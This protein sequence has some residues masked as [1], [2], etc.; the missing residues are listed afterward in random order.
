MSGGD[1]HGSGEPGGGRVVELDRIRAE[2]EARQRE[3]AEQLPADPK[4]PGGR[5]DQGGPEDPRFVLDCLANN[6]RGDGILFAALHR[7]R[8]LCNKSKK[9]K[10]WLKWG[11]HHWQYDHLDEAVWAVEEVA[12]TYLQQSARFGAEVAELKA[13]V[14]AAEHKADNRR[15]A[16]DDAGAALADAEAG[17]LS[18][19]IERINK[20]RAALNRRVDRLR[21]VRGA[22]NCL[23][24]AHCIDDPLAIV[25]DELDLQPWL[26]PCQNGVVDLRT[27]ELL[28]GDP[29]DLLLRAVP[30]PFPEGDDVAHYLAT[31]EGFRGVHW[32][33]FIREIHQNDPDIIACLHRVLGYTITGLRTEHFVATFI[34]EG[35]NGKGTLFETLHDVLGELAWSI[36]PEMILQQRNAKNSAGPS[37]DIMSLQGRRLVVAS[38]TEENRRISAA[39]VKRLTGGDTLTGRAP[40]DKYEINFKPTHKLV[41]YTNHPPKGLASDFAMFR[42]LLYFQYPLRYVDDP[43]HH[44]RNDPQNAH[45]YRQKDPDLPDKLKAEAPWI[46]AWLVRGCLLWQEAGGINPPAKLRAAAEALRLEEDLLGRFLED[47]VEAV[48]AAERV[49]FKAFYE[50]FGEWYAENVDDSDRYRP[51]KKAITDQLRRKG[52]RVPSARETGGQV[53]VYGVALPEFGP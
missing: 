30:F 5:D 4:Q 24:W 13:Q 2:V 46:L 51:K 17:R 14:A 21:S 23:T 33:R 15:V 49:S 25:G 9:D 10:A 11:G 44:R 22:A 43:E 38:E 42:R 35:A 50:A 47:V 20:K 3:E 19:E 31:G 45:I 48:D 41:L 52:Y 32:D 53:Y 40:H 36:E 26:L 28:P 37:A 27:G 8:F 39:K 6:E 18:D 12:L 16:G 1:T 7:G 29:E 34:G